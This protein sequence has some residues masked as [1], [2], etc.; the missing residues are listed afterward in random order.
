[1]R[2]QRALTRT[3]RL[4]HH[5]KLT[6]PRLQQPQ[7]LIRRPHLP[8]RRPTTKKPQPEKL[9]ILQ[10]PPRLHRQRLSNHHPP[11]RNHPQNSSSLQ[12]PTRRIPP[13]K[14]VRRRHRQP[15]T[16]SRN[17]HPQTLITTSKI[18]PPPIQLHPLHH[19][20]KPRQRS[21][22]TNHPLPPPGGVSACPRSYVAA[23]LRPGIV[24]LG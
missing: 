4:I 12:T 17:L 24:T 1:M 18:T 6:I 22:E 9:E 19:T 3:R 11:N 13:L 2:K 16:T 20:I 8:R 5:H 14:P 23:P 7:N 10:R 15:R 21:S